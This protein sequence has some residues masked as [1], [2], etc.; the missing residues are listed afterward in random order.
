MLLQ[1]D[2]YVCSIRPGISGEEAAHELIT[3]A[4]KVR[5]DLGVKNGD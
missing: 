5:R 1:D 2:G 4:N 3:A